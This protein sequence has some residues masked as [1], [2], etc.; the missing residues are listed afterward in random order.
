M[1]QKIT[2]IWDATS[3][4]RRMVRDL[5]V[6]LYESGSVVQFVVMGKQREWDMFIPLAKFRE[7]NPDV[8]VE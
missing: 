5:R 2:E 3:G 4:K 8:N 7:T 6:V 1:T